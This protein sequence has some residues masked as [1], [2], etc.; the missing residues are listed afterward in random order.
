MNV[1]SHFLFMANYNARMNKQ[2]LSIT[3]NLSQD[4]LTENK[5]A[6]FHSILGT[7]NHIL[8]GD[9]IWLT[10]FNLHSER[11]ESLKD[12]IKLPKPKGLNDIL[13]PDVKSF[14]YAR[15]IIDLAIIKWL[16]SDIDKMD[17]CHNLEYSNTKGVKSSRNFGE[18]VSHLFNH[19]T[20]HRGQVSTL[21]N[22]MGHDIGATDYLFDIPEMSA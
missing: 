16:G 6:Y 19:Q 1:K 15:R 21:L 8:V 12:I 9:I 5:G 3:E 17:F 13:Y 18:L 2:I 10:R 22:Q 7:L 4:E 20:H 11:Y 14:T